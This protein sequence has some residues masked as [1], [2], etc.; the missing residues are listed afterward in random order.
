MK[1]L[2]L[3]FA[4][5]SLVILSAC[6]AT[7]TGNGGLT[8]EDVR[9]IV[10]EEFGSE[11]FTTKVEEGI[12]AY[13]AKQEEEMRRQQEEANKPQKVE[14]VSADDDPFK[15]DADAPVTIIE[16]SDYECPFCKRHIDQV[17][18]QLLENYVETGQ[19]KYVFR[20]FP[21][22]FHPNAF[23][24]AVAANCARDQGDD[25]TYFEY[26]DI[27][28]ANQQELT[29]ENFVT[30]AGEMDL[31]TAEF[32]ECLESGKFD[33][34]VE[35]DIADGSSYGVSGTPGFFINGWFI[36]GAFPYSSFEELIEQELNGGA[37]VEEDA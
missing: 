27:L 5:L 19:V 24:A 11:E 2:K 7:S 30:W 21:L 32:E 29:P 31:D 12:E 8:E 6:T 13:I 15:G 36:K 17:Y 34:E 1:H 3:T 10:I 25:E 14:G 35:Q 37:E 33:E 20:D 26:H 23:P 22:S 18:P 16:F 4:V 28:F 9:Q